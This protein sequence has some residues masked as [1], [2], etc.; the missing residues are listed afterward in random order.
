[1]RLVSFLAFLGAAAPAVAAEKA[2]LVLKL[3]H[4]GL[5]DAVVRTLDD[6]VRNQIKKSLPKQKLLPAPALD[7]PAMQVAA[8]C[9]DD[10]ASCLASI[11]DTMGGGLVVRVRLSGAQKKADLEITMVRVVTGK[12]DSYRAE[13]REV[14][15]ASELELRW[16]VEKALGF[17]PAPLFGTLNLVTASK[18]G[19]LEGAE[20]FLD[21]KKVP[22]VAL[23][24]LEPG[25]HRLEIIQQGFENFIWVGVVRP[26]RETAVMVSFEP[27]TVAVAPPADVTP[28]IAE[29]P[30]PPVTLT[31]EI[32]ASG[33]PEDEPKL[34]FTWIFGAGAIIS[35][36]VGT[37]AWLMFTTSTKPE[38]ER[39]AGDPAS[40]E[41]ERVRK[42]AELNDQ[43]S[44]Q[45]N[46]NYVST[47][48]AA[49]LGVATIVAFF[50]E[51]GPDLFGRDDTQV[52]VGIT[53]DGAHATFELR[54]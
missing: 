26:G 42:L 11:G 1:M 22:K 32:V 46:I 21:D 23:E 8:G 7:L 37:V 39:V 40:P 51:G 17:K 14:D 44:R 13:L 24:R 30:P 33:P 31:P 9:A 18:M 5:E 16:H 47:G 53:P 50:L 6:A 15:A 35:A 2:V 19:S 38:A 45:K 20:I 49:G 34:R 52:A 36:T 28:P 3:E 43:A 27:K 54:F 12:L 29:A 25:Q 48:V 41:E 4:P 10:T